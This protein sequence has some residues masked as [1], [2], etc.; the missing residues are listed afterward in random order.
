MAAI[1]D[2]MREIV[3]GYLRRPRPRD[4]EVT[5]AQLHHLRMIG[6]MRSPSMSEPSG[7]FR[8][9]SGTPCVVSGYPGGRAELLAVRG[10]SITPTEDVARDEGP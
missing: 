9:H 5:V 6:Q 10:P 7:E 3:G 1:D 8:L 4:I 2:S